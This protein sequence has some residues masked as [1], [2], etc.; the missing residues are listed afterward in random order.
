WYPP[1]AFQ[2]HLPGDHSFGYP[3]ILATQNGDSG[4]LDFGQYGAG[5]WLFIYHDSPKYADWVYN[6]E[7]ILAAVKQ[8]AVVQVVQTIVGSNPLVWAKV[9]HYTRYAEDLAKL[10][11]G[12]DLI[13]LVLGRGISQWVYLITTPAWWTKAII[14]DAARCFGEHGM[15]VRAFSYLQHGRDYET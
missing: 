8:R 4:K 13:L 5:D 2:N 7:S 9:K 10:Y 6:Y 15:F 1:G 12:N 3:S 14:D 11:Y